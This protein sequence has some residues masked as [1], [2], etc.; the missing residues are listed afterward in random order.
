MYDKNDPQNNE[1]S[2]LRTLFAGVAVVGMLYGASQGGRG[3]SGGSYENPKWDY[4]Q[5]NYQ[6]VCRNAGNGQ[7]LVR[8]EQFEN[9]A[10]VRC[11]P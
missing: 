7:Y 9:A 2:T 5:A 3:A 11:Y 1:F 10:P 8:P 4:Q 6:W